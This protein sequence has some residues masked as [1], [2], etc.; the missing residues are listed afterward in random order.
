MTTPTVP[1]PRAQPKTALL[2]ALAFLIGVLSTALVVS[3]T[4]RPVAKPAVTDAGHAGGEAEHG[5]EEAH[6]DLI[7]LTPEAAK[8]AGL[9]VEAVRL[10]RA[11]DFL[12]V[13]GG[14][15]VSPSRV[16]KVTPPVPGKVVRLLAEPGDRVGKG[17]ALLVLDSYELAQAH[18]AVRQAETALAQTR[19]ALQTAKAG[20]AQART[21]EGSVRQALRRQEELARAGAFSQPTLQAAQAEASEAQSALLQAQTEL[22]AHLV[23]LQRAERLYKE[24]LISRAEMEQAQLEH[25]QDE[26]KVE[27]ARTR[28]ASARQTLA[29]EERV[30]R[31][32]LLSKQAVEAAEAQVREAKSEGAR[33]AREEEAAR[34]ALRG[35][36]ASL[37]SAR[38]N[39]EALEGGG[40]TEGAGGLLTLY[41]P[42]GGVVTE[43]QASLGE[44]VERSTALFVIENLTSVFVDANVPEAE[45]SR[46]RVGLPVEIV[47]PAYPGERFSGTVHTVASRVNE[48]T[49][50][51]PVRCVVENRGGKLKPDMFATVRL[52][53]SAH[54]EVVLLPASAVSE[55][56]GERSVYVAEGGGYRKRPVQ[57]EHA[58]GGRLHVLSGLKPGEKVV[59]EGVFVLKSESQ[60]ESLRGH[61]D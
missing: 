14:V 58:T 26:A 33:A 8:T 12:T 17:Q 36:E 44:A 61:E 43:R 57:V 34:T 56:N 9:K 45:L 38:T 23:V 6:S 3:A 39:L 27:Q 10:T 18:S 15:E 28:V 29:R 54:T 13:P 19:A 40:H 47:V 53:T 30:F 21:K 20:V 5:A 49:R 59:T 31:G 2:I 50:S 52:G 1:T 35:A 22:Q 41:A 42:L 32:D 60:K 24:E 7:Q 48:K 46:V 51:V 16:V 4:M 55:Q 11:T 37:T 25:R